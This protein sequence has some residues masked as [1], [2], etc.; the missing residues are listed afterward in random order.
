MDPAA[1]GVHGAKY[2]GVTLEYVPLL[3]VQRDLYAIPRGGERFRSYLRTMIDPD[4]RDLRIPLVNMN[5]MGKEHVPALIDE[6][7]GLNADGAA[8]QAV[9]Q[10]AAVQRE[11]AGSFRVALVVVDDVGGGWTNRFTNDYANR[12]A[13]RPLFS[14]GWL[15]A[16]VWT[17]DPASVARVCQEVATV[18][19]RAAYLLRHGD[20]GSLR[21][22]LSQ[23]G[24]A[25]ARAGCR[26]P[27]LEP[28]ELAYTRQV[29]GPLLER[30]DRPTAMACLYGD[31]SARSLGYPPQGLS[32]FAGLALALHQARS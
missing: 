22:M 15:T 13:T 20:A 6:L 23:E 4:T 7:L 14:R 28:E 12:F 10:A 26:E 9:E 25:M 31:G 16:T 24:Y 30:R 21:E 2:S 19:H 8:G 29:L 11:V 27:A 32:D 17:G 1:G 5:P 3:Q 18:V